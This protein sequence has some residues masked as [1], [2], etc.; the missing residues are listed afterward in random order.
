MFARSDV[1]EL[2]FNRRGLTTSLKL[3][4]EGKVICLVTECGTVSSSD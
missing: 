1:V 3:F 2:T 4:A